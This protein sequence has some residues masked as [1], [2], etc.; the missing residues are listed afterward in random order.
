MLSDLPENAKLEITTSRQF[1][2][3]L[4]EMKLSLAF[5]TYQADKLFLIGLK[6]DGRLHSFRHYFCSACANNG[7]PEPM[8]RAWLG[9]RDS[10]MIN[11]YYHMDR[12]AAKEQISRIE[13]LSK[14]ADGTVSPANK[15][16]VVSHDRPDS[17]KKGATSRPASLV[18][19][20]WLSQ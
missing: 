8:V 12:E 6:P 19:S 2:A 7:V 5:T 4:A 9:H 18:L 17:S 3:W 1:T 14:S 15:V 13:F 20:H 10:K 11:R 16:E